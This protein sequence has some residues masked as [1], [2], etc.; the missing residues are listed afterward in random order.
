M[1]NKLIAGSPLRW[2]RPL[3]AVAVP[4]LSGALIASSAASIWL[5]LLMTA[6]ALTIV[7]LLLRRKQATLFLLCM[8]CGMLHSG[9]YRATRPVSPEQLDGRTITAE[10]VVSSCVFKENTVRCLLQDATLSTGEENVTVKLTMYGADDLSDGDRITVRGVCRMEQTGVFDTYRYYYENGIDLFLSG[11]K[12]LCRQISGKTPLSAN[13][14]ALRES[15]AET[16]S[17]VFPEEDAALLRGVLLGDT[18]ALS[19]QTADLL[20]RAGVRHL[21][22]VSGLHISLAAGAVHLLLQKLRFPRRLCAFCAIAAA[23]F[24]VLL[25][26]YG[27]PAIR[28]GIMT[29]AIFSG[30]I[31]FRKSDPLNSLCGAGLLIVLAAPYA[32]TSASFL[33]SFAATGGLFLLSP[34][35]LRLITERLPLFLRRFSGLFRALIPTL[36]AGLAILPLSIVFFGGISLVSPFSNLLAAPLFPIILCSGFFSL[37]GIP[38]LSD[39]ATQLC[40]FCLQLFREGITVLVKVPFAFLGTRSPF[41]FFFLLLSAGALL[42]LWIRR[43]KVV[44]CVRLCAVLLLLLP[45]VFLPLQALSPVVVCTAFSSYSTQILVLEQGQT[46]DLVIIG[47]GG[48]WGS[49]VLS[50]L[51]SRNIRALRSVILLAPDSVSSSSATLIT[52]NFPV[53]HMVLYKENPFSDYAEARLTL[54]KAPVLIAENTRRIPASGIDIRR[55]NGGFTLL[56]D[57]GEKTICLSDSLPEE[58]FDLLL[59]S[60]ETTAGLHLSGNQPVIILNVPDSFTAS[61]GRFYSAESGFVSA[62]LLKK[63]K[64][65]IWRS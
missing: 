22:V 37:I 65:G 21:F 62:F 45:M 15:C 23:G 9:V 7:S 14:A 35:L 39:A 30:R 17:T 59:L 46:A 40:S 51:R 26:G 31:F 2:N 60:S 53:E 27:I 12:I 19:D 16:L 1:N 5:F 8:L 13:I 38:I 43:R 34:A 20:N 29:A 42:F 49:S 33:M 54:S 28:A 50:F 57:C 36:S 56:F 44:L 48:N 61:G 47:D 11:R 4:F 63:D 25:T 64:I 52:E 18:D 32:V 24:L 58:D 3:T 41:V 55:K 10:G 6:A